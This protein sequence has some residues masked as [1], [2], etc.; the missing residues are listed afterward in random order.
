MATASRRRFPAL[1]SRRNGAAPE[2]AVEGVARLGRRTKDLV[3]R[4]VPGD[5]AVIDHLNIDRIAAEELI[6]TGVRAV[7]NASESSNG[8]YPNAGPLLLARAGVLL[9]DVEDGDPFELL[10]EGERLSDRGRR[11]QRPRRGGPAR[12]RARTRSSS[13]ASSTSSASGSTRRS[14]NSPRTPSPTCAARPTC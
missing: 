7:L 9:V 8:R 6:A 3:K 2:T 13:S 1:L 11:G 5:V 10:R 4:L 14:P 12:P